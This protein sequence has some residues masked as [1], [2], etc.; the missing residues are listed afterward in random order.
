MSSLSELL[1]FGQLVQCSGAV[2]KAVEIFSK[3]VDKHPEDFR[4]YYNRATCLLQ[5]Q[6]P[7]DALASLEGAEG[8]KGCNVDVYGALSKVLITLKRP[9]DAVRRCRQGLAQ[10]ATDAVCLANVN[11]ALRMLDRIDEA[12]LLSWEAMGVPPFDPT[13]DIPSS[14]SS[15]SSSSESAAVTA[16][17]VVVV[18]WGAKYGPEYVNRLQGMVAEHGFPSRPFRLVCF[19][20]DSSGL[21]ATVHVLPLPMEGQAGGDWQGWWNKA[22]LF[23]AAAAEATA[24]PGDHILYLDLDTVVCGPLDFLLEPPPPSSS[25]SQCPRARTLFRTLGAAAFPTEGRP[26]GVNSSVMCWRNGTLTALH[27]FLEAHYAAVTKVLFKF[28]H[29]L[30]MMLGPVTHYIEQEQAHAR[31]IVDYDAY[32]QQGSARAEA[33]L[34]GVSV[35]CFPLRPKPH[36]LAEDSPM[37]VR[38]AGTP[39]HQEE[40]D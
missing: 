5:L 38:W 40:V 10:V 32:A 18:K 7:Q 19:T 31:K 20:E 33:W 16:V 27:A 13:T 36:E 15:S 4:A 8:L 11:V 6:R 2:D 29:W 14:S 23:S 35:V 9:E 22:H 39:A 37:Y 17:T 1:R 26:C 12:I 34:C 30:E 3:I 25:S 21:D 24:G 28:D